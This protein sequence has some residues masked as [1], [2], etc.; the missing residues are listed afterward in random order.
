M[1]K[2]ACPLVLLGCLLLM[3]LAPVLAQEESVT[4]GVN[5]VNAPYNLTIPEQEVL[6]SDLNRAGVHVIRGAI[7]PGDKG[8]SWAERVYAHGIKIAWIVD[9]GYAPGT[10]WPHA[11]EGF[12]GMWGEP[13][14]SKA[15]PE[16]FRAYF[17]PLLAKLEAKGM[18]LVGFELSNE[19]NWAG[20]NADFPLPGQGRVFLKDDLL[21]DPEGQQI[22]KGFVQY[23]KTLAVLRDIRDHSKLNRHTPILSAGLADLEGMTVGGRIWKKAD[24][25][26]VDVTLDFFRTQGMDELVDGYGLHSYPNQ[27]DPAGRFAHMKQNGLTECRPPGS[28]NGKPC[29]ITEWGIGSV[30]GN[31]PAIDDTK[32]VELVREMRGYFNDFAR[33]DRLKGLFFYTWEGNI[34]QAEAP[35]AAFR[36]GALT[37]S[38]RLAIA[39]M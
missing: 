21:H 4:V 33:Q 7:P 10:P 18:V 37:R 39:P 20:F 25:V 13:P 30:K 16:Q 22:A 3:P 5:L 1:K 28:A 31:C 38:G 19:I 12:K 8:R 17:E 9:C 36:C 23:V 29:W 32:R 24:A 6:L 34:H 27:K 35:V 2:S 11:P 15:D 26:S 14:L